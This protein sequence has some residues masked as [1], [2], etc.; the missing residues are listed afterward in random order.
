M[1]ATT[2]TINSKLSV[3][4]DFREI[5]EMFVSEIPDRVAALVGA[6]DGR[7]WADLRRGA[8]Q[9]KGA[10]GGYGYPELTTVASQLE[11]AV[12]AAQGEE[13][14]KARLDGLVELCTRLRV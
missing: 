3:D 9:L 6:Y 2:D 12:D 13:A 7:Q 5:V 4:P 14:I 11:Y 1:N 8:H 10:G